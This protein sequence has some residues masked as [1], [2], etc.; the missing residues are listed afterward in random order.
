MTDRA[1]FRYALSRLIVLTAAAFVLYGTFLANPPVFDDHW[2]FEQ[3][4]EE[5]SRTVFDLR[6]LPYATIDLTR[7]LVGEGM[8]WLRLENLALHVA[9]AF[10]LFLLLRSLFETVI[11]K[12][13]GAA[14]S[15]RDRLSLHA[16]A[17]AAALLFLLHPVAV[18]AVAYL[19][20]RST[21][22]ATMF[23]LLTWFLFLKG[24]T[25]EKQGWLLASAATYLLSV[26]SKEHATVVPAVSLALFFLVRQAGR[27]SVRQIAPV[28]VLY[29]VI[30]ALV[31]TMR[32]KSG[33]LGNAYEPNV[34]AI[35][36]NLKSDELY[37]LSI[38]TQC[39]LYFKYLFLWLVPVT[40]Q[41]SV[42]MRESLATGLW[43]WPQTAGAAGF[44]LFPVAAGYLLCKK[45]TAGL[46]GFGLLS[47]WLLFATELSA[48]R[49]QE[50]FVL[51]RS[52]LWMPCVGAVFPFLFQ[53]LAARRAMALLAAVVLIFTLLAWNRLTT[54][55]DP[56]LLWDDALRLALK[57][58]HPGN[59]GRMYHNRGVGYL[60]QKRYEDAIRDFALGI[61]HLPGYSP[62]YNDRAVAYLYMGR[63]REAL[64]DFERAIWFDPNYYNPYLGRARAYEALGD[65][66]AARRD[67]ARSCRMG[68]TE[69]CDKY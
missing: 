32:F 56:V 5:Q 68:V 45:G 55:S 51:Y 15:G 66:D 47:S 2:H 35:S 25:A 4:G 34:A 10:L 38:L 37:L 22:M 18:Y 62:L 6:G 33:I 21:L 20:Q 63:Y 42:D 36:G 27:P 48:V 24:M 16:L 19:V 49:A 29:G 50:V 53:K 69:V 11:S 13:L 7:S 52:Y 46:A 44:I 60:N 17:F 1:D 41:M 31:V 64:N 30:A 23:A 58:P 12:N 28:F 39:F 54:F 43:A 67:Y 26:F 8:A 40:S 9:N 3:R 61:Q 59:L 57:K 14:H 65:M